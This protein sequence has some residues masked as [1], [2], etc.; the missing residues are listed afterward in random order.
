MRRARAA[1]LTLLGLGVAHLPASAQI[2]AS[3]TATIAQTIDGTTITLEYSRPSLR[4]RDLHDDLFGHQIPWGRA[5]TPGANSA[6]SLES[7]KDF[8]LHDHPVRAGRWSVW[9]VPTP[10]AW[11]VVLD[12]R[13]ELW[14]TQYPEPA[15]DQVRFEVTPH[16]SA[17]PVPTLSWSFPEVRAD[18]AVLRMQWGSLVVDLDIAV[19]PTARTTFTP[20]EAAPYVGAWEVEQLPGPYGGAYDFTFE[21]RL[22]GGH[23][24]GTWHWGAN[25]ST[26]VALV[27]VAEQIFRFGSLMEGSVASVDEYS[28]LEFEMGADGRAISFGGRNHEDELTHRGTRRD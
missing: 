8:E 6:T 20:E 23:L 2:R 26:D 5:W 3:E 7:N 15:D 12:P 13:D 17:E 9:M 1:L 10:D 22:E 11:E 19:E 18:G 21:L 27:E 28:L 16:T 25:F 14:H 4:G 24:V